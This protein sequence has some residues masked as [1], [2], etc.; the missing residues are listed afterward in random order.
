MSSIRLANSDQARGHACIRKGAAHTCVQGL[1]SWAM[2][3][4]VSLPSDQK[5]YARR[6]RNLGP[7]G[8]Y[9]K[10]TSACLH[11]GVVMFI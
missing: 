1:R 8:K 9:L 11:P 7:A 5:A 6:V 2:A 10:C 4:L 3:M